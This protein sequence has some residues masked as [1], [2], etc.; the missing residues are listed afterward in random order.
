MI[1]KYNNL[2]SNN[3]C[4]Q[5]K[6][7][8]KPNQNSKRSIVSCNVCVCACDVDRLNVRRGGKQ[9][10][11]EKIISIDYKI[12]FIFRSLSIKYSTNTHT[13]RER[14]TICSMKF[15]FHC[16]NHKYKISIGLLFTLSF[17]VHYV[18][19]CCMYECTFVCVFLSVKSDGSK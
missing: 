15:T 16:F 9:Y 12:I 11:N 17:D 14:N 4:G 8:S 6:I 7:F 18:C 10:Y 5:K 1:S 13:E 19:V 2:T 3:N